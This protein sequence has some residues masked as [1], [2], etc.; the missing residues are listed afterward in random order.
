MHILEEKGTRKCDDKILLGMSFLAE[1]G[2]RRGIGSSYMAFR[3]KE[4]SGG[5]GS[6]NQ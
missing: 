1:G 4:L 6:S 3:E 5:Y 2:T